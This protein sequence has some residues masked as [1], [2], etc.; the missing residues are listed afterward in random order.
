MTGYFYVIDLSNNEVIKLDSLGN[1]TKIIGGYG[2]DNNSFDT[3]SDIYATTLNVYVAD[4]FNDRIQ[5]FD[6]DLNFISSLYAS[7]IDNE[8]YK[9]R[10]PI[11]IG[12]SEQGDMFILD[13]DNSRILKFTSSG[14][15]IMPIGTYESG[16]FAL[17]NPKVLTIYNNKIFVVDNQRLLIFDLYG[18][19]VTTLNLDFIPININSTYYGITI[20]SS[21]KI[22][23]SI[24][25]NNFNNYEFREFVPKINEVINDSIIFNNKL[26]ILTPSKIII[27]KFT[28]E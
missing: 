1:D 21:S 4:K 25:K 24:S 20:N 11:G 14:K 10:Y 28:T 23:Y 13:S 8:I 19:N 15:F 18:N 3:P 17:I 12:V 27:Y 22:Y 5:I 16:N 6:K 2:S 9:F 26:Y 7:S